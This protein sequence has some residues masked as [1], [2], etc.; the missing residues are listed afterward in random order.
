MFYSVSSI[1]LI[2]I[3]GVIAL[4]CL[5]TV[6]RKSWF[7]T[8]LKATL[9]FSLVALA[10]ILVLVG[11]DLHRYQSYRYDVPIAK[12]AI[13]RVDDQ[14]YVVDLIV[15]HGDTYQYRLK[16]DLW[17]LDARLI[18]WNGP[19]AT[20]IG[21]TPGYRLDRISG[22][23]LSLDQ[24]VE[25]ERTVYAIVESLSPFDV[26]QWLQSERL[27]PWVDAKYGSA[28]YLPLKDGAEFA[29]SVGLDGLVSRPINSA[30][31]DAVEQ[32]K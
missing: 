5:W 16:G 25:A 11:V 3:A 15:I 21:A 12:L 20:F 24:E 27:V 10:F 31:V 19:F 14:V 26:F 9:A 8:W 28:T 2:A 13:Q 29:I 23:Y 17:Q 7:I 32:W 1:T 18:T 4:S 22:R 30:A 6:F